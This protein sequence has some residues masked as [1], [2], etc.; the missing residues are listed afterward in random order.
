MFGQIQHITAQ[1]HEGFLTPQEYKYRVIMLFS[2]AD[3][4]DLMQFSRAIELIQA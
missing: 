1:F 3:D 4:D 2:E